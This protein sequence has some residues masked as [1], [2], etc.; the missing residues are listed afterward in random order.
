MKKVVELFVGVPCSGKSTHLNENYNHNEIYVISMDNIKYIYAEKMKL[1]YEEFFERPTESEIERNMVSDKY[2]AITENGQWE[3][4]EAA[5][6][7]M[8]KDFSSMVRRSH[9]ALE[10]DKR[11]IVDMTNLTKKERKNAMKWYKDVED[12]HFEATVFEFEENLDLIMDQNRKRG[13]EENKFIADFVIP[14]MVKRFQPI[15]IDEGINEIK[16]VDGLKGLK[17][18]LEL[19]QKEKVEAK[20]VSRKRKNMP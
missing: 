16:F 2:G 9:N 4:L 7:A 18:E 5:N 19:K 10:E 12:V 14:M 13:Q 11:V 17:E 15:E 8:R 3:K 1:G 20:K 6:T